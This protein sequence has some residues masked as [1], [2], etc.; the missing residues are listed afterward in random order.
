[1]VFHGRLWQQSSCRTLGSAGLAEGKLLGL[2]YVEHVDR[3]DACHF[4]IVNR[5]GGDD[6]DTLLVLPHTAADLQP[7]VKAANP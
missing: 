5:V 7:T 1:V 6:A 4:A 3:L 2:R